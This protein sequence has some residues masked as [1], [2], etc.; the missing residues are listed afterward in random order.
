MH[1]TF[2]ILENMLELFKPT[3]ESH[4]PDL[5]FTFKM[6]LLFASTV[7][8]ALGSCDVKQLFSTNVLGIGFP[9]EYTLSGQIMRSSVKL[10][11]GATR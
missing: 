4:S 7:T 2:S 3:M 5:L 1:G 8:T 11:Q 10:L 6:S 9:S